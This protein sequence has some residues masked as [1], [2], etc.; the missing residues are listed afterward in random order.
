[1]SHTLSVLALLAAL[2]AGSAL[3]PAAGAPA[4]SA[5]R[6]PLAAQDPTPAPDPA[7][8]QLATALRPAF[9]GD[10]AANPDMPRY[11]LRLALDPAGRTL[12]GEVQIR[13]TNRS[14]APLE[15]IALRL[16]PNFPRDAFGQGGNV[17][18]R[19][20]A[21]AVDGQAVEP[22]LAARN[23]AALLPLPEPLAPGNRVTLSVGFTATVRPAGDRAWQLIA[24]YPMLAVHDSSGWRLDV[25]TFADKV[26]IES[27]IYR[28]TISAPSSMQVLA[29][30]STVA[31]RATPGG[32]T[33]W[34][35]VAGPVRDFAFVAGNLVPARATAG[36]VAVNVWTARGSRLDSGQIARVAARALE[37]FERR[38]GPYPYREL[39]IHLL[40]GQFDGGDEHS[41]LILLTSDRAVDDGTR[42]V[43]A[44]EVAHQWWYAAV[45]ND[46]Y[47]QPWLDEALAQY[48]GI[49]YAEDS[50][51][52]ATARTDWEREVLRRYRGA[53]ADGDRPIGLGV[54][55]YG[56]FNV[57][58]RTVYGKGPVFLQRLRAELG[59]EAFFGALQRYYADHRYG[60]GT[61]DAIK[62]AFE[63]ASGRDLTDWF[64]Q[65]VRP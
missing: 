60:I 36:E 10:I 46:I 12:S 42:Y 15:Q 6:A 11:D 22:Q 61:T 29:S 24:Y 4:L 35:I 39:D 20:T 31:T 1:M 38:F 58:Y 37:G 54:A 59:D 65:W 23:T 26:Y 5:P 64:K 48:S 34:E 18:M 49:I 33:E 56:S 8:E 21:A 62:R 16:Y 30:G 45:G 41:G 53:V 25:T 19:L 40:P 57:Y 43:A 13:Y 7:E 2:L 63:Q 17:R 52:S 47:H 44:H 27:A 14:G 51:G 55:D 9:A 32:T 50:A 3:A 28:A